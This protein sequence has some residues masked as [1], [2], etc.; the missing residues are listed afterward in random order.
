M[1]A[2]TNTTAPWSDEELKAKVGQ[3]FIVGFYGHA[4]SEDI[5]TLITT[6]KVGTVI[7]FSRN[8]QSGTQLLEL[9]NSL[10]EIAKSA[11]HIQDLFIGI[12]QE[13]GLV[14]RIQPPIATQLPG[15]MALGATKDPA[16]AYKVALA[17]AEM[18]KGFGINMNYAPIADINSEPK[19]PVIGV[20]SP[21][22]DPE[23]VGRFVSAHVKGLQDGGVV[24]CVK[25]FPGHGDTATDSHYGLPVISKSKDLL[26]TCELVPF[27]RAVVKGVDAVMTAHI[28][29]PGIG[30]SKPTEENPSQSL[31]ASLNPDALNI[32]RKDMKYNGLIVSDCL[33]MEGV[34]APY[35]TERAAVMALKAGT[36]CAMICHTMAAQVG[37]I[38]LVVQAVKSGEL[39]Q[40]RIQASVERVHRLKSKYLDSGAATI[41]LTPT[42][43]KSRNQRHADL[44]SEVYGKSTTIVRAEPGIIPLTSNPTANIVFVR[45]AKIPSG[46][47]ILDFEVGE[48][49]ATD[50][51]PLV[52]Y[53]DL[54]QARN[55]SVTEVRFYDGIPLTQVA[56]Q[57]I[58]EAEFVILA[59]GNAD[60]SSYQKEFGLSLGKRLGKKMIAVATCN[61]Y[62]FL[63][64]VGEV[65]N[66]VT[67]YEPTVEAFE[68]AVDVMF[69]AIKPSG[70]LPV[71]TRSPPNMGIRAVTSS[72]K[73]VDKIWS[74]WQEIFTKWPIQR[75]RL[76]EILYKPG[77]KHYLHDNGFCL[78]YSVGDG[79]ARISVVGV[80][81]GFRG[82]GLGTAFVR[83][84]HAELKIVAS[85][86]GQSGLESFGIGSVFPRFWPGIPIDV[87]QV[88]KEFF[89]HRGFR[90]PTGPTS[91]DLFRDITSDVAPPDV[92][93]RVSKLPFKF[94]PWSPALEEEC[95]TKQRAN[96]KC[97]GWVQAYER[98]AA[99]N[100]HHE[101]MVAFDENGA[102]VGWTLMCSPSAIISQELAFLPL[103]PAKEKTGLI[104]CVG[105]DESTRGKGLGLALLIK[106]MENMRERGI[107]GVLIDWVVIRGFYE[108]LGFEAH[109]EYENYDW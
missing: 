23:T 107:E 39:S 63:D 103:M 4:P 82:K 14:T 62:D 33:Q 87:P 17:T 74:L 8:I 43:L 50:T 84:A 65:K 42:D 31:P 12:D 45:P 85:Q 34:A 66:Y 96:F 44:A 35:G 51:D 47:G 24:P 19:N 58:A 52:H 7:L 86:H 78:A 70:I 64:E 81:P 91:R 56:E 25:H 48:G 89:L 105:V 57:A 38:E 40:E 75:Q 1:A 80:L 30:K 83:M 98:L 16:N 3:L 29:M 72:D 32:L 106:A 10:Q 109:F 95:M 99:A 68:S 93:D 97:T 92:V 27:R 18:L 22:D 88:D 15:A 108:R 71:G 6:H 49:A 36:D 76:A 104:A 77:W 37:A 100:Q 46:G 9:T 21:S 102:Q 90:G 61:P 55:P 41:T 59:T 67:I 28:T 94:T 54:L 73:D 53:I 26:E 11:G 20:R 101:V 5:K 13:N 2:I 60:L 69:G 79:H